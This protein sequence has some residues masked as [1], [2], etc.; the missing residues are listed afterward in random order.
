MLC[1]RAAAHDAAVLLLALQAFHAASGRLQ[2]V[3]QQALSFRAAQA[4][5]SSQLDQLYSMPAMHDGVQQ[6]LQRLQLC[7]IALLQRVEVVEVRAVLLCLWVADGAAVLP[8]AS[9]RHV[10]APSV[11]AASTACSQALPVHHATSA[12][13]ACDASRATPE[14]AGLAAAARLEL[15][16]WQARLP[17]AQQLAQ[18]GSRHRLMLLQLMLLAEQAPSSSSS[19]GCGCAVEA[20]PSVVSADEAAAAAAAL[21]SYHLVRQ[22]TS[23][24]GCCWRRRLAGVPASELL[25]WLYR[26]AQT[27]ALL[28]RVCGI[29]HGEQQLQQQVRAADALAVWLLARPMLAPDVAT[30]H[31][32]SLQVSAA[33]T[34]LRRLQLQLSSSRVVGCFMLVGLPALQQ[35]LASIGGQLQA[36]QQQACHQGVAA[37][38]QAARAL[39]QDMQATV[40]VCMQWPRQSCMLQRP[41][42]TPP[43]CRC[44]QACERAQVQ[45]LRLHNLCSHP[46]LCGCIPLS[47]Q[48]GCAAATRLWAAAL[49]QLC[50]SSC[51]GSGGSGSS[52][53]RGA[54]AAPALLQHMA[55]LAAAAQQAAAE[56]QRARDVAAAAASQELQRRWPLLGLVEQEALAQLLERLPSLFRAAAAGSPLVLP[57]SLLDGLFR[58]VHCLLP[59][60]SRWLQQQPESCTPGWHGSLGQAGAPAVVSGCA[61]EPF[62]AAAKQQ[63][64]AAGCGA[65]VQICG[66]AAAPAACGAS[67]VLPLCCDDSGGGGVLWRL[68]ACPA[69]VLQ[70]LHAAAAEALRQQTLR[71]LQTAQQAPVRCEC[72]CVCV[73]VLLWLC[74]HTCLCS[75]Q[76]TTL[77][78]PHA[79]LLCPCSWPTGLPAAAARH[80]CWQMRCCGRARPPARCSGWL[81]G[82]AV[83]SG[84][85]RTLHPCR[86]RTWRRPCAAS[87]WI[88][89]AWKHA[90]TRWQQRMMASSSGSGAHGPAA[91]LAR[92][93][94]GL[95]KAA[96]A[97]AASRHHVPQLLP[98]C[99]PSAVSNP[100]APTA[101]HVGGSSRPLCWAC[102][103]CWRRQFA[104]AMPLRASWRLA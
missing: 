54:P 77:I 83:R 99:R 10:N 103:P 82:T 90:R 87:R 38:W 12:D 24:G 27:A 70:E 42:C 91:A 13:A 104:T 62:A 56:M 14:E 72:V 35:D 45:L 11:N 61:D 76:S 44:A 89:A 101:R 2:Q 43:A 3:L 79:A 58:G 74:M 57:A 66:L 97:A 68:D 6:L 60:G 92:P 19:C 71:A 17:A 8:A 5:W 18:L 94:L 20:A 23:G 93:T 50:S 84:R 75:A 26:S 100:S 4:D 55:G 16:A 81:S 1:A 36:L 29:A 64:A 37:E 15:A 32:L 51:G 34:A 67:D 9:R 85:W 65:A 21:L 53:P 63:A 41:Q 69:A 7:G 39:Q 102:R 30:W 31:V 40:Q 49:I 98:L 80:C 88:G 48:E 73:C 95:A 33:D 78:T 96:V 52:S 59:A 25:V 86:W 28:Q 46:A 22:G 47:A